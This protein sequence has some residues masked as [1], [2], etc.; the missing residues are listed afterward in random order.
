M[1]I[2]VNSFHT[3]QSYTRKIHF[4]IIQ[5]RPRFRLLFVGLPLQRIGFLR[6]WY[7]GLQS[8]LGVGFSPSTSLLPFQHHSSIVPH[9]F[10]NSFFLITA[11]L[12]LSPSRTSVHFPLSHACNMPSPSN[13]KRRSHPNNT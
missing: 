11:F 6:K 4:T 7:F 10:M 2:T 9:A 5:P 13:L 12:H 8:V 3:P 1:L